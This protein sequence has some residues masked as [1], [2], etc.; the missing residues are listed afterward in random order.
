[1]TLDKKTKGSWLLAQS[2]NLDAVIGAGRLEH[3]SYAG[4]VGRLY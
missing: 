2:K 3:I 4:Q 1:M